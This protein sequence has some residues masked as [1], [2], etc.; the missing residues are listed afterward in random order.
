MLWRPQKI[1]L[2]GLSTM[3]P[4]TGRTFYVE[5]EQIVPLNNKIREIKSQIHAEIVRILVA[6]TNLIKSNIEDFIKSEKNRCR[7]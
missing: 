6:F 5:P 3:S 2:T 4:A 1:K 7:N